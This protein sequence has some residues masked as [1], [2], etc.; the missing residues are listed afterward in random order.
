[1]V[2][3]QPSKPPFD[4]EAYLREVTPE[5]EQ[6]GI[7]AALEQECSI[8]VTRFGEPHGKPKKW[9][10]NGCMVDG[11]PAANRWQEF[12]L[13]FLGFVPLLLFF[14]VARWVKWLVRVDAPAPKST[15]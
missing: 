12:G 6:Q 7:A 8:T 11:D 2:Q 5:E 9:W 3:A 1:V 15:A 14:L 10:G 4:P 13:S